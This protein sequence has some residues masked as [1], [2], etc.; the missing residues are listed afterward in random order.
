MKNSGLNVLE[1]VPNLFLLSKPKTGSYPVFTTESH[2]V[3]HTG[4]LMIREPPL[5]IPV[6]TTQQ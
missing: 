1:S 2:Q 3:D 4:L 6:K 5:K